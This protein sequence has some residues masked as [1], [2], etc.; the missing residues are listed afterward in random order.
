M[1]TNIYTRRIPNE[2]DKLEMSQLSLDGDILGLEL[3]VAEFKSIHIG[4]Q[5]KG[6]R[7]FFNHNDWKY[8]KNIQEMKTWLQDCELVDEYGTLLNQEEFWEDVKQRQSLKSHITEWPSA[9]I[10][11]DEYEFST[12]TDFC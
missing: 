9:Y 8:Y 10:V 5:D 7:F 11:K 6:W 12:S 3:K 1:N 4:K 2:D